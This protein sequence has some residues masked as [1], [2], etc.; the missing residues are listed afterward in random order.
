MKYNK[1]IFHIIT[2]FQSGGAEQIAKSL[3]IGTKDDFSETYVISLKGVIDCVGEKLKSD[4]ESSGVNVDVASFS[5]SYIKFPISAFLFSKK[6][7]IC[8]L[9]II[10]LHTDIPE[11]WGAC[12]SLFCCP[13]FVRTIHNTRFWPNRKKLAKFVENRLKKSILIGVTNDASNA[14]RRFLFE[15]G[16]S[17]GEKNIYSTIYNGVEIPKQEKFSFLDGNVKNFLF[18]GR[19]TAQKGIDTLLSSVC[20]LKEKNISNCVFHIIGNGELFDLSKEIVNKNDLP[21]IFHGEIANASK[22]MS[23]FDCIL[24]PSRFEGFGIVAVEAMMN[25]V[26]IIATN[27]PGLREVFSDNTSNLVDVDNAST[28]SEFIESFI[29]DHEKYRKGV[30]EFNEMAM[31]LFSVNTMCSKYKDIYNAI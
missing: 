15:L 30:D 6:Y 12:L 24:M 2:A 11:F 16:L 10:H 3:A 20:L 8:N 14:H 31:R 18:I 26:P 27:A 13:K 25:S 21:V 7:K 28:L 5:N 1:R 29:S 23:S 22:Y 19:L 4:L 17:Y 9:D